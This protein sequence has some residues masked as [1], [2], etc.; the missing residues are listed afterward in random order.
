MRPIA[1]PFLALALVAALSACAAPV[2]QAPAPVANTPE[3]APARLVYENRPTSASSLA[4]RVIDDATGLPIKVAGAVRFDDRVEFVPTDRVG[5][6]DV[7][8]VEPGL[9]TIVTIAQ[10]FVPRMDTVVVRDRS[11]VAIEMRLLRTPVEAGMLVRPAAAT[12]AYV[13]P[14]SINAP[15]RAPT[16]LASAP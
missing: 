13:V 3:R 12:T 1:P 10:G 6:V 9:H 4:A 14:S 16:D 11:G 5:H 8:D 2:R 7:A 15:R